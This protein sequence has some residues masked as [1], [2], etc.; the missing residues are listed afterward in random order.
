VR[1]IRALQASR[2]ENAYDDY[3]YDKLEGQQSEWSR[4]KQPP[5]ASSELSQSG[6]DHDEPPDHE[7]IPD[8]VNLAV[9][10]FHGLA[11][12]AQVQIAQVSETPRRKCKLKQPDRQRDNQPRAKTIWHVC[13][14]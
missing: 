8:S 4:K 3:E 14:L 10:N 12:I 1:S 7:Q 6:N 2:S 11:A 5:A 9:G 13:Y